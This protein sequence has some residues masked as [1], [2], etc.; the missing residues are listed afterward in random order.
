MAFNFDTWGT[1][2]H[3]PT[4]TPG[5]S[6][7]QSKG[8][9]FDTWGT[10]VDNPSAHATSLGITTRLNSAF[11]SANPDST[12][13]NVATG[14]AK[15]AFGGEVEAA[16]GV[17]GLGKGFLG[18]V[19]SGIDKLT[20]GRTNLAGAAQNTGFQT[21][22]PNSQQNANLK[23]SL[24]PQGTAETAGGYVGDAAALGA[25]LLTAPELSLDKIGLSGLTKLAENGRLDQE[26]FN[27][28]KDGVTSKWGQKATHFLEDYIVGAGTKAGE[29]V[30]DN[31]SGGTAKAGL[32]TAVAGQ[33]LRPLAS[34]LT[35][36]FTS[37]GNAARSTKA[38]QSTEETMNKSERRQ[39]I[40][41]GRLKTG[42]V[43]SSEYVPSDTE[44]RAGE[45]LSG[46]TTGNPVKDVAVVKKEIATRGKEA[47][48]YLGSDPKPVSD[49]ENKDMFSNKRA[50]S[51]KYLNQD[52]LNAYD[53]QVSMFNKL[54]PKNPT[55]ADYY[56]SLKDYE[57]NVGSRLAKGKDALIDPT[58]RASAK[59]HAA[60]DIRTVVRD[61][62]G[63]KHPK[64]KSKMFDIASLYDAKGTLLT[65]ADQMEPNFIKRFAKK[66][67]VIAGAAGV[68]GLEKA[69]SYAIDKTKQAFGLG[70]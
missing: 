17:Q 58:G 63:E 52:E 4:A 64:F 45:I 12:A 6:P 47:E 14:V 37:E 2:V 60:S 1:P 59:L 41:E 66:H 62:I 57:D 46:K 51:E 19:G 15:K 35:D 50:E 40:N 27:A 42:S 61:M 34:K 9:N 54:L 53:E 32:T 8:F 13:T 5:S 69:G 10:P 20:G 30:A 55:T 23:Q 67:P 44:K 31:T 3:N 39:A 56:A 28:I 24:A 29:N 18:M 36:R 25:Q 65:K 49:A 33:I 43:S 22:D 68:L 7:T 11:Q 16:Q 70:D 26:T 48:T 38:V 21:L